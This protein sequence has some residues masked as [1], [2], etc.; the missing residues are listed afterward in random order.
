MRARFRLHVWTCVLLA[1]RAR[2]C[3]VVHG[4]LEL[5]GDSWR[6]IEQSP[7]LVGTC[8]RRGFEGNGAVLFTEVESTF[9]VVHRE[10]ATGAGIRLVHTG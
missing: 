1:M 9:A 3:A 7:I 8:S 4:G 2:V 10:G 6:V 5:P